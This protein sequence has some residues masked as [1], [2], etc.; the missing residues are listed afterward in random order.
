MEAGRSEESVVLTVGS[1]DG[2]GLAK[3]VEIGRSEELEVS[4]LC[5]PADSL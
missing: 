3:A 1:G 4:W 2:C 5:S